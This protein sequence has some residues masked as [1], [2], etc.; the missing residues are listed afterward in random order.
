M[1][2]V[3]V[4][5]KELSKDLWSIGHVDRLSAKAQPGGSDLHLI[6]NDVILKSVGCL[7]DYDF[8]FQFKDENSY[9]RFKEFLTLIPE[10]PISLEDG[11]KLRVHC[12]S[13]FN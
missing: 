4:S 12:I 11:D 9:R 8:D 2:K 7:I 3:T 6:S 1:A 13:T 5:S 10:Q